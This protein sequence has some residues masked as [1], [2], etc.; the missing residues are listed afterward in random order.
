MIKFKI[1]QAS[2]LTKRW[3]R[4]AEFF[5]NVSQEIR[6]SVA[7]LTDKEVKEQIRFYYGENN[8]YKNLVEKLVLSVLM[9]TG[10]N[11][12]IFIGALRQALSNLGVDWV[13]MKNKYDNYKQVKEEM[14]MILSPQK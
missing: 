14:E 1:I 4:S 8:V 13:K 3:T 6:D 9:Y 12:R 7:P 2:D 11:N 10:W 5:C